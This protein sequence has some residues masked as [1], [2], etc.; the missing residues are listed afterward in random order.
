MEEWLNY[1]LEDLLLFSRETYLRLFELYHRDVWPAHILAAAF[2]LAMLPA[3]LHGRLARI[4][5]VLVVLAA[6]WAWVAYVFHA[7]RYAEINWAAENFGWLFAAQAGLMVLAAIW[8]G[9]LRPGAVWARWTGAAVFV[10]ALVVLP[11]AGLALGR[12]WSQV[13]FFALTPDPTAIA[14]LGVMVALAGAW[15]WAL[16][17]IPLAWCVIGGGTLLA[18]DSPEAYIL[19]GAAGVGL[20]SIILGSVTKGQPPT[21]TASR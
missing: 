4:Q 18:M 20:F 11:L 8:P 7:Q 9:D 10:F 6:M 2:G 16:A 1:P 15:R 3:I 14:T 12:A 19:W 17:L 13:E 5:A 21:S